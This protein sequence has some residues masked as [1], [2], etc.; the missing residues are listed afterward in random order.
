MASTRRAT[1]DLKFSLLTTSVTCSSSGNKTISAHGVGW[2]G[3]TFCTHQTIRG[4][5]ISIQFSSKVKD[6]MSDGWAKDGWKSG[7]GASLKGT[8]HGEEE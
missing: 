5:F 6:I 8:R 1:C 4:G 3:E 7:R 2:L